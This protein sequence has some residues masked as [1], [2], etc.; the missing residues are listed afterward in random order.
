MPLASDDS[1]RVLAR[2]EKLADTFVSMNRVPDLA[3]PTG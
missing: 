2:W 1:R 3:A